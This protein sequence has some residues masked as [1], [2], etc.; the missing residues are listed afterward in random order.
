[1]DERSKYHHELPKHPDYGWDLGAY[2][3]SDV[4]GRSAIAMPKIVE[5]ANEE[6]R[7]DREAQGSPDHH[8]LIPATME[9]CVREVGRACKAA[10]FDAKVE[11]WGW[12]ASFDQA[13]EIRIRVGE[14]GAGY[15]F[16]ITV[17]VAT[18]SRMQ[19]DAE[20]GV[21]CVMRLFAEELETDKKI[22]AMLP[23][24]YPFLGNP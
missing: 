1:M 19:R 24:P 21:R 23:R 5:K 6:E 9:C 2:C 22:V 3:E 10:G 7:L 4:T 14:P 8:V 12:C 18:Y 13:Y 16:T 17:R 15:N 20:E 11:G